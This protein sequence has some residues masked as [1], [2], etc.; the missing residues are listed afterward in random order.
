[1]MMSVADQARRAKT[2]VSCDG[3]YGDR[4]WRSTRRLRLL[5]RVGGVSKNKAG[6]V[7]PLA[8]RTFSLLETFIFRLGLF[9]I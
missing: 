4:S 3:S 2:C 8:S 9:S 1:M 5:G 6:V 7:G